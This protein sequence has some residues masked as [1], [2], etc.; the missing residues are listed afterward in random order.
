MSHL[1][2]ADSSPLVR[3][4][5]LMSPNPLQ[6][7]TSGFEIHAPGRGI[8]PRTPVTVTSSFGDQQWQPTPTKDKGKSKPAVDVQRRGVGPGLTYV[9]CLKR[10]KL[11]PLSSVFPRFSYPDVNF[12]IWVFGRR[13]RSVIKGWEASLKGPIK[14]A[15]RR[16]NWSGAALATFYSAVRQAL[17]V[18]IVIR[19]IVT[20]ALGV[21]IGWWLLRR[22]RD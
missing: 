17:V 14:A 13:Y 16:T 6:P 7:S 4:A 1:P 3:P 18:A 20:G 8:E 10:I 5:Q 21:G 11:M 19:A 22:W 2:T 15:D 12:W 9:R